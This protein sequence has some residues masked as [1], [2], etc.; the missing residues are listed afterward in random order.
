MTQDS[1]TAETAKVVAQSG[2][3]P[4]LR[5][6]H[7]FVW[8]AVSAALLA[9][10]SNT[11]AAVQVE[12]W[13]MLIQL[14]DVLAAALAVTCCGLGLMWRRRGLPFPSQP[15][16]GLLIWYALSF[17]LSLVHGVLWL[18][19][20]RP[21]G[22]SNQWTTSPPPGMD[23]LEWGQI[24]TALASV[25]FLVW[26]AWWVRPARRWQIVFVLNALAA[27]HYYIARFLPW[28]VLNSVGELQL[29]G[30]TLYAGMWFILAHFPQSIPGIAL[31]VAIVRD[32]RAGIPRHWSHWAGVAAWCANF[33]AY[34]I[35]ALMNAGWLPNPF[36]LEPV[37]PEIIVE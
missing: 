28:D 36:T 1:T 13:W 30:P 6:H 18:A 29:I 19:I 2:R 37:A 32:R 20:Y 9:L 8:T 3:L 11:Y 21:G 25:A 24:L 10:S 27:G 23:F 7:F 16:H 5:L 14:P 17:T 33:I 35:F 31:I 15:G 12:R 22:A 26:C 34:F 4:P